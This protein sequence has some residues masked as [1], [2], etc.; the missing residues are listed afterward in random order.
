LRETNTIIKNEK[1]Q[2]QHQRE[3]LHGKRKGVVK[4]LSGPNSFM[5]MIRTTISATT[6]QGW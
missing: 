6:I 1:T 5:P 3:K 4:R 2:D